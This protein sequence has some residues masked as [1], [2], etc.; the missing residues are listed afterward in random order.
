MC[1]KI[2]NDSFLFFDLVL[3]TVDFLAIKVL[4]LIL[5]LIE[6]LFHDAVFLDFILKLLFGNLVPV[7]MF[8]PIIFFWFL[9]YFFHEAIELLVEL[10]ELSL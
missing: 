7:L 6:L 2:L 5:E 10:F 8:F 3:K 9:L 4:K 1:I